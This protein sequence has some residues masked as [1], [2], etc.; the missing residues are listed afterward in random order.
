M[1]WPLLTAIAAI[2]L[3]ITETASESTR[4]IHSIPLSYVNRVVLGVGTAFNWLILQTTGR[5][6]TQFFWYPRAPSRKRSADAS[7]IVLS[8]DTRVYDCIAHGRG[9][10]S[11]EGR[12]AQQQG[13]SWAILKL[14]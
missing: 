3:S 1:A 2:G 9:A 5:T 13:V 10:R 14:A 4:A 7:L 8:A 11:Q 12:A 6:G